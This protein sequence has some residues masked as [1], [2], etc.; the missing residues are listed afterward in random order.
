M[1]SS[2]TIFAVI[3]Q[4]VTETSPHSFISSLLLPAYRPFAERRK[5]VFN[6]FSFS[7]YLSFLVSVHPDGQEHTCSPPWCASDTWTLS[8]GFV[9]VSCFFSLHLSGFII[10]CPS[11]GLFHLIIQQWKY[12]CFSSHQE[13]KN[14]SWM[15]CDE[16]WRHFSDVGSTIT[17]LTR[18]P[19]VYS[20]PG[21]FFYFYFPCLWL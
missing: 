16:S 8:W 19:A 10:C 1:S 20:S 7:C 15:R 2:F 18:C 3:Y 4:N 6:S 11:P 21:F 12:N 13:N 14:T 9:S 5:N 17:G